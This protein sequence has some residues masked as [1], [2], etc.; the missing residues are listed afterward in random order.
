VVEEQGHG[1]GAMNKNKQ[2]LTQK[3]H[4]LTAK[5]KYLRAKRRYTGLTH[6]AALLDWVAVFVAFT[7]FIFMTAWLSWPDSDYMDQAGPIFIRTV[8]VSVP[9]TAGMWGVSRAVRRGSAVPAAMAEKIPLAQVNPDGSMGGTT[10]KDLKAGK[11]STPFATQD[12][13]KEETDENTK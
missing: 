7:S 13:P 2:T 12:Q 5:E 6:R 3:E 8:L 4:D 9:L 10:Y 11:D 1:D